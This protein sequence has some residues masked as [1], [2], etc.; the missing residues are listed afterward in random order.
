MLACGD[1]LVRH[2]TRFKILIVRRSTLRISGM[3]TRGSEWC[4][5]G[6]L[7]RVDLA[8][9][10]AFSVLFLGLSV[11]W[12]RIAWRSSPDEYVRYLQSWR[13]RNWR[14][15]PV[16]GWFWSFC[17]SMP[18]ATLW[19]TPLRVPPRHLYG[20][21]WPPCSRCDCVSPATGNPGVWRVEALLMLMKPWP[22]NNALQRTDFAG[23]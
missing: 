23:G 22:P 19:Q 15:W 12:G 18:S 1:C 16:Y 13:P 7:T 6:E 20:S 5:N 14:K 11:Y 10:A 3:Q 8:L 4:V 21:L 9:F 2:A 17:D